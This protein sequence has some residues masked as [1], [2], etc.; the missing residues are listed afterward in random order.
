MPAEAIFS[1]SSD[2][3]G[4]DYTPAGDGQENIS[5]PVGEEGWG[6]G[7]VTCSFICSAGAVERLAAHL[8]LSLA[9]SVLLTAPPALH[10]P[11]SSAPS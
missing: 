2:L 6:S 4:R 1:P 5:L 11:P 3:F 10:R 8:S 7:H 9:A